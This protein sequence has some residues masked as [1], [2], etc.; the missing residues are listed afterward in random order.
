M[1]DLS[2]GKLSKLNKDDSKEKVVQ[3][4]NSS[5]KIGSALHYDYCVPPIDNVQVEFEISTDNLGRVSIN[6]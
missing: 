1:F 2:K 3:T 6:P 4:Q 5:L